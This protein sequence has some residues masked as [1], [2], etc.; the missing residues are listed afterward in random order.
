MS[1]RKTLQLGETRSIEEKNMH[2]TKPGKK[3][4]LKRKSEEPSGCK[5]APKMKSKQ[6][7]SPPP[8][9]PQNDVVTPTSIA[10]T[11]GS[12]QPIRGLFRADNRGA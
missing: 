11:N 5:S 9:Q 8:N 1:F 6:N 7:P 3:V 2:G 4:G 12:Q 10:F